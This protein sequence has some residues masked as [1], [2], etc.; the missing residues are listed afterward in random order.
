MAA[1]KA[2]A[3]RAPAKKAPAKRGPTTVTAEHKAAMAK[4]R[5]ASSAVGAYLDALEVAKPRRRRELSSE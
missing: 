5:A 1:K 2:P 3:K 4:G